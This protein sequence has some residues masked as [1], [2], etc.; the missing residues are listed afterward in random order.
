[1]GY[2][3]IETNADERWH[4]WFAWHPVQRYYETLD[5]GTRLDL[6]CWWVWVER[7][8]LPIPEEWDY[9]TIAVP[10]GKCG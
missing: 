1:M 4:R 6:R 5:D 3:F 8:W 2:R 10:R 7:R 9:R